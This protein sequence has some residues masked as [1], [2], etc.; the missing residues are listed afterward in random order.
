MEIPATMELL[1][2]NEIWVCD[3][4]ASNHFTKSKTGGVNFRSD[5]GKVSQ[6]MTGAAVK[7][8]VMDLKLTQ[9]SKVGV[10]RGET[11]KL[12][13]VSY[14][15]SFQYNLF[16]PAR[17]LVKG[18]EMTGNSDHMRLKRQTSL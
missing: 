17:L 2:S 16:S 9:Y 7:N 3:S 10:I 1:K 11:F 12:T 13:D 8:A 4:G 15:K 5:S 18:W 14:S 6:G